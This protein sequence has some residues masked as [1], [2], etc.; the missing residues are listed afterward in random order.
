[1]RRQIA[2]RKREKFKHI[3]PIDPVSATPPKDWPGWPAGKR[4][5]LLLSHDV[6]TQKGR[7]NCMKLAQ[8][9][10]DLGFRSSF[11]FVPERYQNSN[12]LQ[13]NLRDK[14]FGIGVHGLKHDGKLFLNYKIFNQ[15]A[16][17]INSYL[18]KWR[19][20]GFTAP[21]MHHNLNWLKA[22]NISHSTS[23]FDTDP[24]EPQPDASRTIFPFWV[25][26]ENPSTAFLELPYT[27][28]QDHL[29]FI[30]LKE[31]NNNIWKTKL[32]WIAEK[33]GMALL[34]THSDY[35]NFNNRKLGDEE[36]PIEFYTEFLEH[37]K[38]KY[39]D[40]FWNVLPGDV[41]QFLKKSFTK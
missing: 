36:Y 14:G 39:T 6:D 4:F 41:V 25:G 13:K 2:A 18:I 24:F 35:M 33:G 26:K 38:A 15:R 5:A 3:W 8:I 20:E 17:K 12:S 10:Q 23:T 7:D 29:L 28:P 30:I 40:Q 9:E 21:S 31:K 27:L 32:D 11:N 22:L 19:T 1:L 16:V 37:T 34:N